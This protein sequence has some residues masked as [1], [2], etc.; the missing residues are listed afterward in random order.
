MISPQ[1]QQQQTLL[2]LIGGKVYIKKQPM[3]TGT[4]NKLSLMEDKFD[5]LENQ[6]VKVMDLLS[7]EPPI[8]YVVQYHSTELRIDGKQQNM[9]TSEQVTENICCATKGS[10]FDTELITKLSMDSCKSRN[11]M[12]EKTLLIDTIK[13]SKGAINDVSKVPYIKTTK[14]AVEQE[15]SMTGISTKATTQSLQL[16]TLNILAKYLRSN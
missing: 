3:I 10:A 2:Q 5:I 4:M 15:N 14:R 1:L 6:K 16:D 11:R 8:S 9:N 12:R 7:T 13:V